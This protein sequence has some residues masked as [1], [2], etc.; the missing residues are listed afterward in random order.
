V[1]PR[2]PT[3]RGL[4]RRRLG[5]NGEAQAAEWYAARGYE[6]VER[7]WRCS[8]G[9]VD[10]VLRTGNTIVFCEVKTRSSDRFGTALEAVTPTKQRRLR[11]LGARWL[12]E[13]RSHGRVAA[14]FDVASVM[15]GDITVIEN[16]F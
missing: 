7:N 14:R 5:V 15:A 13:H 4:A 6:V 9:E 12:A 11:K 1:T 3:A 8:D 2:P 10:L 16:A